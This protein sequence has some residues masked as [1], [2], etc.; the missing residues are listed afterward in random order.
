MK[1]QINREAEM[2]KSESERGEGGVQVNCRK[3]RRI[4]N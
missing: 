3:G 2:S 4:G 1:R